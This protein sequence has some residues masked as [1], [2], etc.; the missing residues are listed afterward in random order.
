MS[1]AA[2]LP[3]HAAA[4]AATGDAPRAAPEA[5][6]S[7]AAASPAA[8][9]AAA[10]GAPPSDVVE[11]HR[12]ARADARAPR[13]APGAP[14]AGELAGVISGAVRAM[15]ERS[16]D[17]A[18][19]VEG[20]ETL[21]ALKEQ[22]FLAFGDD[23]PADAFSVVL[24]ALE[25]HAAHAGVQAAGCLALAQLLETASHASVKCAVR[26][27]VACAAAARA[28]SGHLTELAVQGSG[29][30]L[31][32]CMDIWASPEVA[33]DVILAQ[34][35][36][37]DAMRAHGAHVDLLA[38]ALA[39][40]STCV[41]LGCSAQEAVAASELL[42]LMQTH[43]NHAALQ[44]SCCRI[45]YMT[46]RKG[47]VL[48][49]ACASH[50]RDIVTALQAHA[51]HVGVQYWGLHAAVELLLAAASGA[52]RLDV[53]LRCDLYDA[54]CAA[55]AAHGADED[56][57]C[58][59]MH[60]MW[61]V[62]SATRL[63]VAQ[64]QHGSVAAVAALRTA[65][66]ER[67][68]RAAAALLAAVAFQ[69]AL[70]KA[71]ACAEAIAQ[72]ALPVL[73]RVMTLHKDD[74]TL[75]EHACLAC[76]RLCGDPDACKQA[77]NAGLMEAVIAALNAH[78]APSAYKLCSY[79]I[80]TLALL[81]GS[82][83]AAQSL[84]RH[85]RGALDAIA[86]AMRAHPT[87]VGLQERGCDA[88]C[89]LAPH[90]A[91]DASA[92]GAA[93]GAIASALQAPVTHADAVTRA[94]VLPKG[95]AAL[96]VLTKYCSRFDAQPASHAAAIS[97]LV[98]LLQLANL[99]E[100]P[101]LQLD[102]SL[103]LSSL[104]VFSEANVEHAVAEGCLELLVRLLSLWRHSHEGFGTMSSLLGYISV[105]NPVLRERALRAGAVEPL[106]R[107]LRMPGLPA[108]THAHVCSTLAALLTGSESRELDD[109]AQMERAI[110]AGLRSAAPV[111]RL[112][113]LLRQY[114]RREKA[115]RGAAAT[116]SQRNGDA[117]GAADAAANAAAAALL[118]E[119]EAAAEAAAAAAQR[120]TSRN[121]KKKD[122]AQRSEAE[123]EQQP[124][125]DAAGS[126]SSAPLHAAASVD[127]LLSSSAGH[128]PPAPGA[129]APLMDFVQA[130][131]AAT[132]PPP[133][134]VLPPAPPL[135]SMLPPP[136]PPT[137][138]APAPPRSAV[139]PPRGPPRPYCPPSAV[140]GGGI[141]ASAAAAAA[142]AA[143]A[144]AP[145]MLPPLAAAPQPAAPAPPRRAA[146]TAPP[147]HPLPGCPC[148]ADVAD[149]VAKLSATLA[150][151]EE[152][153]TCVVCLDGARATV[154]LPCWHLA[155]CGSPGCV[156]MLGAP[157]LCPM[158]RVAVARFQ[159][160]FM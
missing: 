135:A 19:Q 71:D 148:C 84:R 119:E 47:A 113:A 4:G 159:P 93:V 63:S 6:L 79:G 160:I 17:A 129:A 144:A 44:E 62:A 9:A 132:A 88:A 10:T 65:S 114:D 1:D 37:L 41:H 155:L 147:R 108:E 82:P 105:N 149:E 22:G 33:P 90:D 34:R 23:V 45:L 51:V 117:A 95:L 139:V 133:S 18:V 61:R 134:P 112:K 54:A 40:L 127:A 130:P 142:A 123:D 154:L 30:Q 57:R 85:A 55:L 25:A 7:L 150:K 143:S 131:L 145:S 96:A 110:A 137:P 122:K 38:A 136:A 75:Q 20:C 92:A 13:A 107:G 91:E 24:E 60:I 67:E 104:A 59:S 157:P 153:R 87:A 77:V 35:C 138:P 3:L 49:D 69:S 12:G 80:D 101:R 26:A 43:T 28:M 46:Y 118:A 126:A 125:G 27:D 120:R 2:Q 121:R 94:P 15:R 152:E 83:A 8:A 97:M 32:H 115:P 70:L 98:Q 16:A 66:E 103:A 42:W 72:S 146:T 78:A 68:L 81:A 124:A 86:A 31:I 89:K 141:A 64:L 73:A 36:V 29:C 56:V 99:E 11:A 128:A 102:A 74:V 100:P 116:A 48:A 50:L 58:A 109:E 52:V 156:A 53:A 5:V 39:A 21:R 76:C 140:P 158:C 151:L 106:V 111:G 14:R